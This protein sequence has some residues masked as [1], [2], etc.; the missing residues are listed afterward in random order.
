MKKLDFTNKK[1]GRLQILREVGKTDAGTYL[2]ECLCDCGNTTIVKSSHL[3]GNHTLSC[4][5]WNI[6]KTGNMNRSHSMSKTRFYE[7]W[8]GINQRCNNKKDDRYLDYGGRGIKNKWI[9]FE[10]FY[11]EMYPSYLIHLA[12]FGEKQTTIDRID[13]NKNYCKKNCKWST[14]KEQNNNRRKRGT[15]LIALSKIK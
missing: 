3:T 7:I 6:E 5:C 13:N 2:W 9:K 8:K 10:S 15:G 1:I 11:K 14:Y 4:G 12:E